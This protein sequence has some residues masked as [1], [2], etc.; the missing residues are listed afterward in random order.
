[1]HTN[2]PLFVRSDLRFDGENDGFERILDPSDANGVEGTSVPIEIT[3]EQREVMK[4]QLAKRELVSNV[5]TLK[6]NTDFEVSDVG[7]E[8]TSQE[9]KKT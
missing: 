8:S 6:M 3:D 7:V 1:M 4:K 2:A 5:S 9:I